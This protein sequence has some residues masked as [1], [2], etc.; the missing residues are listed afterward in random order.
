MVYGLVGMMVLVPGIRRVFGLSDGACLLA[1]ILVLAVMLLPST[2]KV[3]VTALEAVPR[4]YESAALLFTVGFACTL[5]GY[6]S[7]LFSA[8]STLTVALYSSP[9]PRR[10]ASSTQPL[11][12]PP[13]CCWPSCWICAPPE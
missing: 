1:A 8:G 13:F 5:N 6:F 7:G 9:M 2:I 11:P 3:S 4:E 12:S 10:R